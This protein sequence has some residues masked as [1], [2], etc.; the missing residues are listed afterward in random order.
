MKVEV[1]YFT[2]CPNHD[3]TV[4]LVHEVAR[5]LGLRVTVKELEVTSAE[6][7]ARVR[8]LGSPSVHV[9]GIDIEPSARSSTGYAFACRTYG[10]L[11]VPPR[12][13]LVAALKEAATGSAA[14]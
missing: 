4:G 2:G 12:E 7:A 14:R 1:L 13:L 9:N 3:A 6:D 8:F 10:D 11:R 5:E